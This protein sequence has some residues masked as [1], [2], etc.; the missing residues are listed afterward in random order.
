MNINQVASNVT[1]EDSL[2]F[3]ENRVLLFFSFLDII[4]NPQ[5]YIFNS[6]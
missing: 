4:I 1:F 2:F 5:L 6:F 3:E